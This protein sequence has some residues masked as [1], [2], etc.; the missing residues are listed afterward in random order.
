MR[1]DNYLIRTNE[2]LESFAKEGLRTLLLAEKEL[3]EDFYVKWNKKY[4]LAIVS[5]SERDEKVAALAE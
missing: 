5:M 2:Y 1:D 4:Q 3:S